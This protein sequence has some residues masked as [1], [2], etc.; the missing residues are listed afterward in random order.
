MPADLPG[1]RSLPVFKPGDSDPASRGFCENSFSS[2]L[3]A[4]EFFFHNV[5]S[6]EGLVNTGITTA[7]TGSLQNRIIKSVE[8]VHI[9]ADGSV[10]SGSNSIISFTYEDGFDAS[11]L[12]NMKINND[13]MPFFRNIDQ[14]ANIINNKYNV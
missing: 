12:T 3:T 6:R 9:G 1:G 4:E 8:D 14:L 10:R 2:Q 13:S 5:G 11:H 7:E